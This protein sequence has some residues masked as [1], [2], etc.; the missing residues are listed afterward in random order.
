ML[1]DTFLIVT[2][3]EEL[4]SRRKPHVNAV[5]AQALFGHFSVNV[6]LI[7]I[8]FTR[9]GPIQAASSAA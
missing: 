8:S 9:S 5:D 2:R 7:A 3:P 1:P 6:K 4:R